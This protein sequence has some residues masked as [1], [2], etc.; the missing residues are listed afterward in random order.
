VPADKRGTDAP[1]EAGIAVDLKC[2][3]RHLRHMLG[4]RTH[5]EI[6]IDL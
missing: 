3:D 4:S 6:A 1:A 2:S 5:R